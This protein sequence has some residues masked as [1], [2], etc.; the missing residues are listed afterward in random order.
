MKVENISS[1]INETS[2]R[3][4]YR[5]INGDYASQKIYESEVKFGA[6]SKY[7]QNINLT[8]ETGETYLNEVHEQSVHLDHFSDGSKGQTLDFDANSTIKTL[9][10]PK[11]AEL[12]TA[13][14]KVGNSSIDD[15]NATVLTIEEEFETESS[16]DVYMKASLPKMFKVFPNGTKEESSYEIVS[17]YGALGYCGDWEAD[18]TSPHSNYIEW[19]WYGPYCADDYSWHYLDVDDDGYTEIYMLVGETY[20]AWAACEAEG[21]Y[22]IADFINYADTTSHG[23]YDGNCNEDYEQ[24]KW[25]HYY[26][27][28]SSSINYPEMYCKVSTYWWGWDNNETI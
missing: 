7:P 28:T 21:A 16:Q 13:K 19:V 10:I 26:S 12:Q 24:T 22:T 6:D 27:S 1:F 20:S 25:S 5:Y 15:L 17:T 2:I 14:L 3:W 4:Y 8:L 9:K 23:C 11:Y 18:P